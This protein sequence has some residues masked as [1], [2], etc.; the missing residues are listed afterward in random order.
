MD[1]YDAV[2]Q[3]F[4]NG[5]SAGYAAGRRSVERNHGRW[6]PQ[7]FLGKKVF[8]CSECQTLGTRSWKSCPVCDT[9]MDLP[10][11]TDQAQAAI[12][13]MGRKAHGEE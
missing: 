3:A 6:V 13:K 2:E 8:G 7:L 12:E 9:K 10:P 4:A 5:Y 1:K 11:I